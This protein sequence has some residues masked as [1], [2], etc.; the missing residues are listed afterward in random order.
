VHSLETAHDAIKWRQPSWET[1]FMSDLFPV[2]DFIA[3]NSDNPDEL[4]ARWAAEKI[5]PKEETPKMSSNLLTRLVDEQISAI[6]AAE[7]KAESAKR[8]QETQLIAQKDQLLRKTFS[9]LIETGEA[10]VQAGYLYFDHAGRKFRVHREAD[11]WMLEGRDINVP[12]EGEHADILLKLA[13]TL[14][15]CLKKVSV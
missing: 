1:N 12:I 10:H 9:R 15:K 4:R 14:A 5:T 2:R 11:Q 3:A 7:A 6:E 13:A 8:E